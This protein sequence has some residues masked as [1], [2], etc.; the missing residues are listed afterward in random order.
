[1]SRNG[2]CTVNVPVALYNKVRLLIR[3]EDELGYRSISEFA[4]EAIR[5]RTEE[6]ENRHH[7]TIQKRGTE[8][9]VRE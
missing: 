8:N 1:M 9:L 4:I 5:K 7:N 6:I 3:A 2:Y